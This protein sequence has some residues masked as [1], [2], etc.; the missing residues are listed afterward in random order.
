MIVLSSLNGF[1]IYYSINLPDH[2]KNVVDV[3]NATTQCYLKGESELIGI[4]TS[5][6]TSKVVTTHS[7]SKDVS[8]TLINNV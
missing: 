7:E 8:V 1:T 4:L 3:M 2:V 5:S 6:D